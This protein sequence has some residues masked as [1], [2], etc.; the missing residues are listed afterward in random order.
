[1]TRREAM[2]FSHLLAPGRIASMEIRN[3]IVMAPMG[4]NLAAEDGHVGERLIRYYEERARGGVGLIIVGVGAVAHP[5]GVCIP[6]QVAISN[7]GFLPGLEALTRRLQAHGAKVAIQLQHGGKVAR[8]DMEAGRPMWV[9]SVPTLAAGDLLNDL[10]PD[11]I[12]AVIGHL[13]KPGAAVRFHEMTT[14]D[15][16]VLIEQFADAAQRARRA[17]FDGVEIH[18][19]HGYLLASFLS[20]ASNRR[21]DE[22]GGS[23]ENR[24]RLLVEVI[25]AVK[26]RAGSD[27]PVWCRLDGREFHIE[28]GVTI[29]DAQHTAVLAE[30]AGADAI[31]V[32]AYADPRSGVAF[33]DA[34][35]VH[36]PCGYVDLAAA[37][38]AHVRAPV[39]AVGRIEPAEA[40]AVIGAGKADFVAMARK[41]LA[42]PELPR[43]LAGARPQHI[44]PCIYGYSCVGNI[45]LNRS[46][47]CAVNPATGRESETGIRPVSRPRQVLVAGGGPSGMEAA[48]IAALRGHRVTLCE[49]R[50]HLG[51]AAVLA[52]LVYAPNG[53][54]V[55]HLIAEVRALPIEVRLGQELT[56]DLVRNLQ[57]DLVLIATGAVAALP[58]IPGTGRANILSVAD[59][60]SPMV[61]HDLSPGT[62]IAIVGN[63]MIGIEV[64]E[65]FSQRGADV[66][67]LGQ[68]AT[69]G[70]GMALPRRW[71]ALHTLRQ[72]G[73]RLFAGARL[74]AFTDDGVEFSDNGERHHLA[75][76]VVM[77]ATG[78]HGDHSLADALDDLGIESHRL[79]DCRKPGDIESALAD[80]ARIAASV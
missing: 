1:V 55:E 17:G 4:S 67:V 74:E 49:R 62:R 59:L 6:K 64:A 57:P 10:T 24:A 30:A 3:R 11:E 40:D 54:L 33:T 61:Q 56:L 14:A 77:L 69:S 58:A 44:R 8:Q 32:S 48:R 68:S 71:R 12:Q 46:V 73:V 76:D 72:R 21:T 63:G 66:S 27:F 15:I 75:A 47:G 26:E 9:P 29:E 39:I 16:G 28:N 60:A 42:D 19:A 13:A 34:P 53:A 41:L 50:A 37:I 79:G 22:Y 20:P 35:L 23:L 70:V 18:A 7:D 38:K 45:F 25:G 65:F 2:A 52:A 43:K 78:F 80:A 5:A 31:H 36:Q 51:G